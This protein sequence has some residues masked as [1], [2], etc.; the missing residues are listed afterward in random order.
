MHYDLEMIE[1]VGY[2]SGVENYSRHFEGRLPGETPSNLIEYFPD[3]FLMVVDESHVTL[4]QLHGMYNGDR[5][6]KQNLVDYGFRLP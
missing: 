4:P 3:D 1:N 5:S 6:R 2:C